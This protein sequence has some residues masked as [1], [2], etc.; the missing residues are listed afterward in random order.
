[1]KRYRENR[2][3]LSICLLFAALLVAGC[4]SKEDTPPDDTDDMEEYSDGQD[5]LCDRI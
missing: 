1:M 3:K 2:I 4:G 5:C